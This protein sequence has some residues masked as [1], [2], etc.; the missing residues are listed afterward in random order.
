MKVGGKRSTKER[1]WVKKGRSGGSDWPSLSSHQTSS[2]SV[3]SWG[4]RR[5]RAGL[6][7]PLW[8]CSQGDARSSFLWS[9]DKT[10]LASTH[11]RIT[12]KSIV[13]LKRVLKCAISL[14]GKNIIQKGKLFWDQE[15]FFQS[16]GGVMWIQ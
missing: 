1:R 11:R 10:D 14:Y 13:R 8:I 2:S 12:N 7:G 15:N 3:G 16:N 4:S 6:W 9:S 5:C